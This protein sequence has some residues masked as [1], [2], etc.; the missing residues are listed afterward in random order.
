MFNKNKK[1]KTV[2]NSTN[3]SPSVNIINEG[4]KIKGNLHASSDIRVSGTI[5]GEAISKGKIILTNNG[6][7]KGNVSSSDADIAGKVEGDV[8]VSS[9]LILRKEAIVDGN[10]FTKT[11]VVE[12]GAQING[13]CKMGSDVKTLSHDNDA[14]YAEET[15]LKGVKA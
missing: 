5:V 15:Q 4:T 6:L 11:L 10:I 14:D 12:E 8:R 9:R 2:S 7:V 1:S 13:T 3:Q